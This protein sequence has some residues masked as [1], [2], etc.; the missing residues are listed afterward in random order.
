MMDLK[1]ILVVAGL[2]AFAFVA[3][4]ILAVGSEVDS[5]CDPYSGWYPEEC[6]QGDDE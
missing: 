1:V 3:Y 5:F 6:E 4:A 2:A